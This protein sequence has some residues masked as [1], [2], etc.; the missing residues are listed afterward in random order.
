MQQKDWGGG[1][2]IILTMLF[3]QLYT[4]QK[5]GSP[6]DEDKW[7]PI[8]VFDGRCLALP[9]PILITK[10]AKEA[11]RSHFENTFYNKNTT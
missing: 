2:P 9:A 5:G 11:G 4:P 1:D 8:T 7:G 10:W 6:T 3:T